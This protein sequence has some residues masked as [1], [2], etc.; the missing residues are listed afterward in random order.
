MT[1][2]R[3]R[4]TV[5]LVS[6]LLPLL[7]L[8]QNQTTSPY[9]FFGIG[10]VND[11]VNIRTFGMG[12]AN[13]AVRSNMYINFSN[14][15]SYTGID[16]LSFVAGIGI[17]ST[18]AS[19]RTNEQTSNLENTSVNHLSFAFPIT[20]WWKTSI[21][22]T[23]YSNVGYEV[24]EDKVLDINVLSRNIYQ[25]TG[26]V[27]RINWGNAF[28]LSKNFSV[29]MN[30][31][32]Y[33]GRVEHRTS[34][35]FPDSAYIE[36]TRLT[37]RDLINGFALSFGVQYFIPTGKNSF[38]GLAATYS[39]TASLK[40]DSDLLATTFIGDEEGYEVGID[41]VYVQTGFEGETVLPY[42]YGFGISWE[43]KNKLLIAADF[44]FD[45]WSDFTYLNES[46]NLSDKMKASFGL[47]YIPTSN[48]LSNYFKLVHYRVGFRYQKMG[49]EFNNNDLAEYAISVGFGL[50]LRKSATILNLGIEVG[51]NGTLESS[52]IQERFVKVA[53]GISIKESW[54]RKGKYF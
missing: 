29:G 6:M 7:V 16:S 3:L 37:E 17:Q 40:I 52:L 24:Q 51:Q 35:I 34:V 12:G 45:N 42:T 4:K 53:L 23:P 32:Y 27:D 10:D 20:H 9:S 8:A 1:I 11:Q 47:E 13:L 49:L 25:G 41:T 22:L 48:S 14:P 33:F 5:L 19:Y 26:G 44:M 38:I 46:N 36:N 54:F 21:A 39:P 30:A 2:N 28:E 50:P 18:M 43:K 31:S 15:A